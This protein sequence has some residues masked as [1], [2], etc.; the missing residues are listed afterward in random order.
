M[1]QTQDVVVRLRDPGVYVATFTRA[2]YDEVTNKATGEV[3]ECIRWEFT[4]DDDT[5][6][7][8]L[9]SREFGGGSN[10]S[11]VARGIIG[12]PLANDDKL[13][14]FYGTTVN[15]VWGENKGGKMTITD[16]LPYK[17]KAGK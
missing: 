13:G 2:V 9:T 5:V 11:K 7:D 1:D 17:S 14:A 16:V 6:I 15:V 12:R 3:W 10:A 4:E 8:C